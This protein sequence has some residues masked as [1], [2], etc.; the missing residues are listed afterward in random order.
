M[1]YNTLS[2]NT[3][4]NLVA[5]IEDPTSGTGSGTS[6]TADLSSVMPYAITDTITDLSVGVSLGNSL[7]GGFDVL[8]SSTTNT[9]GGLKNVQSINSQQLP[10][11]QSHLQDGF[12]REEFKFL[13]KIYEL[14]DAFDPEK[15]NRSQVHQLMEKLRHQF[16]RGRNILEN[17]PGVDLVR[18]QQD[19]LIH[20]QKE[21]LLKRKAQRQKYLNLPLLKN[22]SGPRA[23]HHRSL[24]K[25]IDTRADDN[26]GSSI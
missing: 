7:L 14:F 16:E 1:D 12:P 26:G 4:D 17:L 20:N 2:P 3:I 9:T 11:Q 18:E 21:Y 10:P 24:S 19:R 6:T 22:T 23:T 13:P 15:D 5:F 8:D 25:L